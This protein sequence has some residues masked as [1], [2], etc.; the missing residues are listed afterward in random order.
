[1]RLVTGALPGGSLMLV[2]GSAGML[3]RFFLLRR[4]GARTNPLLAPPHPSYGWVM[5]ALGL[6]FYALAWINLPAGEPVTPWLWF[7]CGVGL[8]TAV[9]VPGVVLVA[10]DMPRVRAWAG[11]ATSPHPPLRGSIGW[12]LIILGVVGFGVLLPI[13][14]ILLRT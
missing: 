9:A 3:L 8:G 10:M 4:P 7:I 1:M 5:W 14:V 6:A 13:T 12:A 2:L 11:D